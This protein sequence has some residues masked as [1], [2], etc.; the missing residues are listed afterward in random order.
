MN[1]TCLIALSNNNA[2]L[3]TN[4]T[5][6]KTVPVVKMGQEKNTCPLCITTLCEASI[7][8]VLHSLSHYMYQ[9]SVCLKV[10]GDAPCNYW[11]YKAVATHVKSN[12]KL[13]QLLGI[14]KLCI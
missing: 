8:S 14:T 5:E 13:L 12:W 11:K 2:I 9:Y 3:N 1:L 4:M 6:H 10:S 7:T